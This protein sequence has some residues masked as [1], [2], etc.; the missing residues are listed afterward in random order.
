MPARRNANESG[1][2]RCGVYPDFIGNPVVG[3]FLS[4]DI[5]VQNPNNTQCYNRYSYC[6][7]NPLK[8]S[9]PSGWSYDRGW[10]RWHQPSDVGFRQRTIDLIFSKNWK[11]SE[12][13]ELA[14]LLEMAGGNSINNTAI[15]YQDICGNMIYTENTLSNNNFLIMSPSF[16]KEYNNLITQ[17]K[18]KEAATYMINYFRMAE[19]V[20]GED[21]SCKYEIVEREIGSF[22]TIDPTETQGEDVVDNN[23]DKLPTKIRVVKPIMSYATPEWVYYALY[24]EFIHVFQFQVLGMFGNPNRNEREFFAY[25]YTIRHAIDN[26]YSVRIDQETFDGGSDEFNNGGWRWKLNGYYNNLSHFLMI[27]YKSFYNSTWLLYR[28]N[29]N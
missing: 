25:S 14:G 12:F 26:R 3:R 1:N 17:K 24:H 21:L 7:N 23:G 22:G 15:D 9:D 16:K 10:L 18:F 5:I 20:L 27:K 6:I 29:P 2:G 4:P 28:Y 8:Y 13:K 11:Q 19:S